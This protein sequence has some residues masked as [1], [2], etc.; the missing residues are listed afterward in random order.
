LG[1]KENSANRKGV[2]ILDE[3]I[4]PLPYLSVV[5]VGSVSNPGFNQ[6]SGS[7]GSKMTHKK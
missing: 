2:L 1:E 5:L 6:V 7:R 4:F 3:D